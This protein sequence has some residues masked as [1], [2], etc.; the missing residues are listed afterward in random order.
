MSS[1]EIDQAS[2]DAKRYAA[3]DALRRKS[4]EL[5]NRGEELLYQAK[6]AQKKLGPDVYKRQILAPA[7]MSAANSPSARL[8]VSM[9]LPWFPA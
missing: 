5:R 4:A 2:R 1:A 7:G 6:S 9:G 8:A 3:E